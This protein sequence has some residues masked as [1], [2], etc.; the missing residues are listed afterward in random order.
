MWPV[1]G[2]DEVGRGAIAG[3]VV[4]ADIILV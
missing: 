2:I 4:V 1:A 3:P